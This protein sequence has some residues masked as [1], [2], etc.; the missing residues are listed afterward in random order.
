MKNKLGRGPLRTKNSCDG[1]G[2]KI[3]F[4]PTFVR[5]R[6]TSRRRS[7]RSVTGTGVYA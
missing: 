1:K 7:A 2:C 5:N 6:K 3:T 4:L